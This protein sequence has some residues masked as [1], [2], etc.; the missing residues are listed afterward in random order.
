VID[1]QSDLENGIGVRFAIF[2][3]NEI[4]QFAHAP[5]EFPLEGGEVPGSTVESDGLPPL[6]GDAG[7]LD[8]EAHRH[9]AVDGERGDNG[10][11]RRIE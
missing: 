5:S 9:V 7:P 6:R 10:T 4:G 11:G 2:L 8:G 1:D 3:V